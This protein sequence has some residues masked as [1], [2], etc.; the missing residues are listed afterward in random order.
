[1]TNDDASQSNGPGHLNRRAFL[2]GAL[3]S[4][5]AFALR[6][7]VYVLGTGSVTFDPWLHDDLSPVVTLPDS[8]TRHWLGP[9]LWG[10]RL[11][12]WRVHDGRIECLRGG[13]GYEVRTV[14]LLTREIVAGD[15]PGHFRVRTGLLDGATSGGFCGFLIGVGGDDLDYRA[16]ALAQRGSGIGGGLLCTYDTDGHV[17]FREHTDEV[18][19]L[20]F[21][22]LSAVTFPDEDPPSPAPDE[23]IELALDLLPQGD[24]RV[25][26]LFTARDGTTGELLAGAVRKNVRDAVVQGNIALVSSPPSHDAGARWWFDQLRTGGEKVAAYPERRFGPIAGTLYSLNDDVLKL[27]AQLLPIADA[28]PQTVRFEYRPAD[29]AEA[30]WQGTRTTLGPG[31]TAVFRLEHWDTS[32]AWDYRVV[33]HDSTDQRWTYHGRIASDPGATGTC[34]IGMLGC[35]IASVRSLE[36]GSGSP[37]FPFAQVMG[38]YTHD[39]I[40]V[41]YTTLRRNVAAHDPDLLVFSGDQLYEHRPTRVEHRDDPGLDYLYK[42]VLWHWSFRDLTR[43]RPTIVLVDDHDVYQSNLWGE[44]GAAI[45]PPALRRG[46]YV[47]EADFI[48]RAQRVQCGHNP[49]PYDPTPI[50]RN[51]GVYYGQFTYGGV[52]FSLLEDRKFKDGCQPAH[53]RRCATTLLGERQEA[54]L[55]A[56]ATDEDAPVNICLTQTCFACATTTPTGQPHRD[57]DSNGYPPAGR[58]RAIRLLQEA[59]ALVVS[60]DQHLATLLRHGI[61]THTDGVLQFTGPA[62]GVIFQ[63]WFEPTDSLPHGT[64]HPNTGDFT[65]AFGNPFRMLA[66]ANPPL[67]FAAYRQ[68]YGQGQVIHDRQFKV[69]GYGI[70]HVD[71]S[72][73]TI[74]LE[75]WPWDAAP[76]APAHQYPGWP[77]T[78]SFDAL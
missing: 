12:D 54:F 40:Y 5:A 68:Y 39:N 53:Q 72:S 43:D 27:S 64:G 32:R 47:G 33:Y 6:G 57:Y 55:R 58:N 41:P 51:I 50:R 70:V 13:E 37:Q 67:S 75:C 42:W 15:R 9:A 21:A 14:A 77:Y 66:V 10:N 38:R 44:K 26:L 34:T 17:R 3:A 20:R 78:V 45:Q 30:E 1:M 29:T 25:D 74:T 52:N 59:N 46:G 18:H 31:Y 36:A 23:P 56:W 65:D 69:E 35:T 22:E 2:T 61:D 24:D 28:A 19:P 73:D 49:D 4:G 71:Y 76:T 48:N 62:G 60:G 11:Q 16:A 63:R 7:G 8:V